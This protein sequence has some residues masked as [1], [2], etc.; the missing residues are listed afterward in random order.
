MISKI[1]DFVVVF[2]SLLMFFGIYVGYAGGITTAAAIL[3][4][5]FS[6][7]LAILLSIKF[8]GKIKVKRKIVF[9]GIIL[10]FVILLSLIMLPEGVFPVTCTDL[11]NHSAATRI[12]AETGS[13]DRGGNS[14]LVPFG[15][16][17]VYSHVYPQGFYAISSMIY[18][19]F[20]NAF[21]INSILAVIF[22]LF[23]GLGVYLIARKV[24]NEHAALI[25]LF[26]SLFSITILTTIESGFMTQL[27]A[28]MF[29][30]AAFYY[31]LEDNKFFFL[32]ATIGTI[33]YPSF[34]G[35][36]ILFLVLESFWK[37]N[38]SK[39]LQ[40]LQ[41]V[42]SKTKFYFVLAIL[43]ALCLY[44][45]V[46]GIISRYFVVESELLKRILLVRGGVYTPNIL[47]LLI[48]APAVVSLYFIAIKKKMKK[49]RP[50]FNMWLAPILMSVAVVSYFI[51]NLILSIVDRTEIHSLYQAVKFFY[52]SLFML[53][54]LSGIA[55]DK[56]FEQSKDK[57][58]KVVILLLL[59][60]N[61]LY[62]IGYLNLYQY[63]DSEPYGFYSV[64]E[65][66]NSLGEDFTLGIDECFLE[67]EVYKNPLIYGSMFDNPD[68][69][70]D[71]QRC[72]TIDS[73]RAFSFSW[74]ESKSLEDRK[75]I[76]NIKTGEEV[77]KYGSTDVDYFLTNC[78]EFDK[79]IV[80]QEGNIIVYKMR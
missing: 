79:E 35:I 28:T 31:Y 21:L 14:E 9:I 32:L 29:L 48:F 25:S 75:G 43:A 24:S 33:A 63:K 56:I 58:L 70:P 36:L 44:P 27:T 37:I 13:F 55:I 38:F 52:F 7:I 77:L 76:F 78:S 62:F 61:L 51:L 50:V 57:R 6:F 66:I 42:V 16:P 19:I 69:E 22:V 15:I 1:F 39:P 45:E 53:S 80:I 64:A 20:S 46:L 41:E 74:A 30:I 2:F 17:L 59:A 26:I 8:G 54:I 34:S 4:G 60:F 67:N 12:I 47:A 5:F 11:A 68:P 40:G 23:S 18:S 72:R 3:F 49:S 10:L 73:G 65:Q 71:T